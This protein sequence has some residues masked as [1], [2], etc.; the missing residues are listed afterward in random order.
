MLG[1]QPILSSIYSLNARANAIFCGNV[2][3]GSSLDQ[4]I[5]Q[6][7]TRVQPGGID[8]LTQATPTVGAL[9]DAPS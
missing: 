5:E 9:K 8:T 6:S 4:R 2:D 1:F 3:H 7:G